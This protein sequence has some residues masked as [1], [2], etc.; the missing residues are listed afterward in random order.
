MKDF[1]LRKY[2]SN[3]PL[4]QSN[5]GGFSITELQQTSK[6]DFE[7]GLAILSEMG[8]DVSKES[9][10]EIKFPSWISNFG[11]NIKSKVLDKFDKIKS[12]K[13]PNKEAREK[14]QA[15]LDQLKLEYSEEWEEIKDMDL[16]DLKNISKIVPQKNLQEDQ[17]D[18]ISDKTLKKSRN[19]R[20]LGG[21]AMLLGY[22]GILASGM[23]ISA[24]E[25]KKY[26]EQTD[27]KA[28]TELVQDVKTEPIIDPN[29]DYVLGGDNVYKTQH[30]KGES[31]IDDKP[32]EARE[33][34][35]A[36][37]IDKMPKGTKADVG[38]K[39]KISSTLGDQDD[40]PNGPK[41][42]GL[43]K[44]RLDQGK[45]VLDIAKEIAAD[46]YD[47]D[48]NIVDQGTNV[49]DALADKSNEVD[50]NSKEALSAQT[51]DYTLLDVDAGDT[52]VV[53][54]DT[55][56]TEANQ[57][58][59]TPPKDIIAFLSKK[60]EFDKSKYEIIF[61]H[62][63]PFIIGNGE[64]GITKSNPTFEK[65]LKT[66][67]FSDKSETLN[68][69]FIAKRLGRPEIK[70]KK[71]GK[72]SKA[73]PSELK[74]RLKDA[75]GDEKKDI[76]DTIKVLTWLRNTKKSPKTIGDFLNKLNPNLEV[77]EKRKFGKQDTRLKKGEKV[78][79]SKSR[80]DFRGPGAK[81][82]KLNNPMNIMPMEYLI[83]EIRSSLLMEFNSSQ[84][85]DYNES[86]AKKNIG[87]LLPIYTTSF[88][89]KATDED[90]G[91]ITYNIDA[92]YDFDE[93]GEPSI[94][95][96]YAKSQE[97]FQKYFKIFPQHK[98]Q[99]KQTKEKE[100]EKIDTKTTT[101][102][103]TTT[104]K[105]T[106]VKVDDT[107]ELDPKA[108]DKKKTSKDSSSISNDL[109][110]TSKLGKDLDNIK[111]S[112]SGKDKKSSKDDSETLARKTDYRKGED[113]VDPSSKNFGDELGKHKQIVTALNLINT[114]DE[115]TNLLVGIMMFISPTLLKNPAKLKATL[116]RTATTSY[117]PEGVPDSER[118]K[119]EKAS[120]DSKQLKPDLK[121]NSFLFSLFEEVEKETSEVFKDV[122][123]VVD[124]IKNKP[125]LL[126]RLKLI[127]SWKSL[128]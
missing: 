64:D 22:I 98:E 56:D 30:Q 7:I 93:K 47:V 119:K 43:G 115:F 24:D 11:T 61:M 112:I 80:K 83:K 5:I 2:M 8:Y 78:T 75:K 117:D 111:K 50:A 82:E 128:E 94:K 101:T 55:G 73:I 6:S 116:I 52:D 21:L 123:K 62:I 96:E 13:D 23:N 118:V 77:G 31:N 29:T 45:E 127:K 41:K 15:A 110:K 27:A 59:K 33:I 66:L 46:E 74:G 35:K 91:T 57:A 102:T 71:T 53:P 69:T 32:E 58:I 100:S 99:A 125:T 70:N 81:P 17:D 105:T 44:E 79:P 49:K 107:I 103:T 60:P 90:D 16:T 120:K 92:I 67:N 122:D 1:D 38:V 10:N 26:A 65:I 72:I 12:S 19:K 4:H 63:L 3:N 34:I 106:D 121:E 51:T 124:L 36:L 87:H 88:K 113:A 126:N 104:S 95:P 9:L 42:K 40:N 89:G 28:K 76:E 14:M 54:D 25:V 20:R 68:D 86:A 97:Y 109:E 114:T 18:D 39:G 84:L 48:I 108:S 85:P 37:G